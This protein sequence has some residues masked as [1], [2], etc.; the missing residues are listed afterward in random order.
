MK[1]KNGEIVGLIDDLSHLVT[2]KIKLKVKGD[3]YLLI[4]RLKPLMDSYKKVR[5]EFI[6][7]NGSGNEK[8]GYS[9]TPKNWEQ[10]EEE[11]KKEWEEL[12]EQENEVESRLK[13]DLLEDIESEHPYQFLFKIL[14]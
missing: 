8:K 10:M 13:L 11:T 9:I 2:E 5:D 6:K 1:V 12:N 4:E 3:V 14:K 7:K